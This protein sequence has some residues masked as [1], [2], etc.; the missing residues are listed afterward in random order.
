MLCKRWSRRK[1]ARPQE[2]LEA[3][4]ALF[5]Q[6]GYAA[7]RIEDIAREAGVTRGTPYLYFANKEEIFKAVIRELLLPEIEE[8]SAQ[9]ANFQGNAAGLLRELV[10]LWWKTMGETSLSALPKLMI[11]EGGNFPEV[12]DVYEREFIHPGQ[13]LFRRVLE[14]GIASGEF[15][16]VNVE[17]TID[18]LA[19]PIVMAMLSRS[20]NVPCGNLAADPQAYLDSFIDVALGGLLARPG[21]VACTAPE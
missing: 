1:E 19:A 13:S 17:Q 7:T 5:V 20:G 15:R 2:I 4:L 10:Q 9:L 12:L 3:A 6:K 16:P 14:M 8:A 18:V 11:A 21:E